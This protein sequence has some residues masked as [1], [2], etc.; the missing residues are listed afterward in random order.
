MPS[1][2]DVITEELIEIDEK[3]SKI[4]KIFLE[5]AE[6]NSQLYDECDVLSVRQSDWAIKRFLLSNNNNEETA[7]KNLTEALQ[8][9]KSY[10]VNARTD[11]YFPED[12]YKIGGI[13]EYETD[14]N[15]LPL[16]YVRVCVHHKVEELIEL[17]RQFF[18]H[19]VNKIDV[20]SGGEWALVFDSTNSGISNVDMDFSRFIVQVLQ[21]YYPKGYKYVLI[22]E[23]P[24]IMM[25]FWKIT[26][27]WVA[28]EV[29]QLIKFASGAQIFDYI[30][31][32]NVPQYIPG[33]KNPKPINRVP[34]GVKSP[35]F[36]PH[37]NFTA[38]QIQ[39]FRNIFNLEN[40]TDSGEEITD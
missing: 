25:A 8:W 2:S 24:W 29:K 37:F 14:K 13:F 33:G 36:L 22:Y 10:G 21:H 31:P 9:K 27:A 20:S 40:N 3:V 39:K 5:D 15:G 1:N 18:V 12:F 19:L 4:R 26:R 30:D 16:L 6:V 17:I 34:E 28:E 32:D 7:L 11:D 23:L 35:E 38:Q